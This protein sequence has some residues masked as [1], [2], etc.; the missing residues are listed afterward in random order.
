MT[1]KNKLIRYQS[2]EVADVFSKEDE[3]IKLVQSGQLSQVL[4]LWQVKSPTLVL[5]AGK[6]WTISEQLE[7]GLADSGWRL[8]SRKTGGAPVP[9]VPGIINLSHIYHWY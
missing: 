3:L 8:F 9:Q 2:K 4:L 1:S 7:Q 6:K 5:P